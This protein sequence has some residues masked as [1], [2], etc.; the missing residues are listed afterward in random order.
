MG[1]LDKISDIENLIKVGPVTVSA[2]VEHP[3][4]GKPKSKDH[5]AAI[6]RSR[7]AFY[8]SEKGKE[9]K[10]RQSNKMHEFYET[11][12]GKELRKHLSQACG[13]SQEHKKAIA[14]KEV[15]REIARLYNEEGMTRSELAVKYGVSTGSIYRYIKE[16]S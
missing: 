12:Q 3:L 2:Y 15:R 9:Q 1:R 8:S 5:K 6:S 16:F 4:T 11:D 13:R 14:D 10:E 7:K